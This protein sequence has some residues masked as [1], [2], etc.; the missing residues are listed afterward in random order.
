MKRILFSGAMIASVLLIGSC[1]EKTE[2]KVLTKEVTFKKEGELKLIRNANDSIVASL[3]IEIADDDYQIQTGLMYRKSMKM[4]HG[5]LFI[6]KYENI[7]SFY[8]KNTEIPLD[9]IYLN[10]SKKVVAISQNTKPFDKTSLSSTAPALYVLEVN[11][12]LTK[13]WNIMPGDRIEWTETK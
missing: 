2:T 7:L 1:K 6:F 9:I 11:A 10:S 3:D 5:M 12:G 13:Q 4:N 8:M